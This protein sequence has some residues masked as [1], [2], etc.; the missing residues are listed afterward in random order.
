M[1]IKISCALMAIAG[2]LGG[3]AFAEDSAPSG[4]NLKVTLGLKAW[5]NKWTS[6]AKA[7]SGAIIAIPTSEELP[8]LPLVSVK[9]KNWS[10]SASS[11]TKTTHKAPSYP[12]QVYVPSKIAA[13]VNYMETPIDREEYD[14]SV[15]YDVLPGLT[16]SLGYKNVKQTFNTAYQITACDAAV[17][18]GYDCPS[19]QNG[20]QRDTDTATYTSTIL[21]VQ[22]SSLLGDT[23]FF[24]YGNASMSIDGSWKF[25][26]SDGL[27][28][29]HNGDYTSTEFGLGY[30]LSKNMVLT[31]GKKHQVIDDKSMGSA[32]V[33]SGFIAGIS[34]TF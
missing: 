9:W 15:G 10:I 20:V 11:Y 2:L 21:G 8:L 34:Y 12:D 19:L 27:S 16:V 25:E 28:I 1:K 13:N 7:Y 33:T 14:I 31:L 5:D 24:V 17:G 4:D 29:Q 26:S 23:K 22:G 30:L 6:A 32:D 18:S 3:G